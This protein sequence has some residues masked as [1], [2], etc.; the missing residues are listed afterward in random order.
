M[1][2]P[3]LV[4][5][6]A[7]TCP[8]TWGDI[9]ASGFFAGGLA[10][11]ANTSF[12]SVSTALLRKREQ[13]IAVRG[14]NIEGR[15][16]VERLNL[17]RGELNLSKSNADRTAGL[18]NRQLNLQEKVAN[19]EL[20]QQQ[21]T[22]AMKWL[23]QNVTAM[24][25]VVD[26]IRAAH[27]DWGPDKIMRDPAFDGVLRTG[28]TFAKIA[29]NEQA[30]DRMAQAMLLKP[31]PEEAAEQEGV[32]TATAQAAQARTLAEQT[33]S[34][35]REALIG[36]GALAEPPPVTT[37][38]RKLDLWDRSGNLLFSEMDAND[39]R[40]A[41]RV[42]SGAIVQ[43]FNE[44]GEVTGFSDLKTGEQGRFTRTEALLAG[45]NPDAPQQLPPGVEPLPGDP[46]IIQAAAPAA[47]LAAPAAAP[48]PVSS[49]ANAAPALQEPGDS[50]SVAGSAFQPPVRPASPEAA[51]IIPD[52]VP[53]DFT[54]KTH[55]KSLESGGAIDRVFGLPGVARYTAN[56]LGD[57]FRLGLASP[58]A[59]GL[60][61]EMALISEDTVVLLA[62]DVQGKTNAEQQKRFRALTVDPA[63]FSTGP[64]RAAKKVDALLGRINSQL[65]GLHQTYFVAGANQVHSGK[66]I[67][68]AAAKAQKLQTMRNVY[69]KLSQML[70]AAGGDMPPANA[71]FRTLGN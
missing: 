53:S 8:L 27:P 70:E 15:L 22:E 6:A 44:N 52:D 28:R 18:Q 31:S 24:E 37:I 23:S 2:G 43:K 34:T 48:T 63:S 49:S 60:G 38:D 12:N 45:L 20:E 69:V 17:R 32:N 46:D 33:D 47:A 7:V 54:S 4:L 29:G 11:G 1:L 61:A 9:V 55:F 26:G 58:E 66:D 41:W 59:A 21:R 51:V 64:G 35:E 19:S 40:K 57:F 36:S 30:M 13:E 67:S 14:Q 56:V 42:A 68:N 10:E 5:V 50:N 62:T 71:Y 25:Q 39:P 3:V 65:E 16:G